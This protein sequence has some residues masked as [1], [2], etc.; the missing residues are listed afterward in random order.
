MGGRIHDSITLQ[1]SPLPRELAVVGGGCIGIEFASLSA[2]YGSQ[3][4]VLDRGPRR[5]P[6]ARCIQRSEGPPH[7][8]MRSRVFRAR[9]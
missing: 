5:L 7:E 1:H 2:Q 3:V 4:T 6:P 8:S 9:G